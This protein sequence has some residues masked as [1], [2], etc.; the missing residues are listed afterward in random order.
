MALRVA[1]LRGRS[2][3]EHALVLADLVEEVGWPTSSRIPTGRRGP[4][5]V[6]NVQSLD[7]WGNEDDGYEINN[8]F[9]AGTLKV[10]TRETISNVLAYR[11]AVAKRLSTSRA[12]D[13]RYHVDDEDLYRY[14]K[15]GYLK[16]HVRRKQIYIEHLL[17]DDD[18]VEI[19]DAKTDE[20]LFQLRMRES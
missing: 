15:R 10:P 11:N 16:P 18:V 13:V 14:L 7:V 5:V 8:W 4:P 3:H 6:F 20:P 2:K 19:Q 9:D 12:V 1:K 17:G